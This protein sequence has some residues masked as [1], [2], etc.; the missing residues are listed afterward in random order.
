[1]VHEFDISRIHLSR[2]WVAN[3]FTNQYLEKIVLKGKKVYKSKTVTSCEEVYGSV[4][5]LN[6]IVLGPI[7]G[8]TMYYVDKQE[9][10]TEQIAKALKYSKIPVTA[11]GGVYANSIG[12]FENIGF[13]SIALQSAIWKNIDPVRAFVEIKNQCR[14]QNQWAA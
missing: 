13:K 2:H 6:E 4:H 11:M 3:F 5:G 10:K 12:F 14:S 7:F 9:L 1:M 8:K